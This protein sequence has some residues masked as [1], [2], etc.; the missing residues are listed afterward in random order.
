MAFAHSDVGV[1]WASH[2]N[3]VY[4][5]ALDI[6]PGIVEV[7]RALVP[8]YVR[9]NR[10]KFAPHLSV[11]RETTMTSPLWGSH[12]GERVAFTYDTLVWE[13][14]VYFWLQAES[15]RLRK[16]RVELGLPPMDW[17]CYPPDLADCFHATVGNLKG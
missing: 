12:D 2:E 14:E 4:R 17:Y 1:L 11:V 5:L 13:G 6:D 10:T 8:K 15:P 9:L 16:I 3:G 7:A